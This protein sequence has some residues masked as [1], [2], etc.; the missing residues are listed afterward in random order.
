MGIGKIKAD[1]GHPLIF[2]AAKFNNQQ[3]NQSDMNNLISGCPCLLLVDYLIKQG[4]FRA[5]KFM[6]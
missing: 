2:Q 6:C 3:L 4:L 5:M 1:Q